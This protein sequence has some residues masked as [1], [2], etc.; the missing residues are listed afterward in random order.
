MFQLINTMNKSEKE[1][2]GKVA[3]VTGGTK[4]IGKAIAD[5]LGSQGATVIVT[6]RKPSEENNGTTLLQQI[7]LLAGI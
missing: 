7:L 3:L 5:K 4:G 6:A 1:L 2:A